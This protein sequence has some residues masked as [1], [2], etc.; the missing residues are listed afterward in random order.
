M[1]GAH[2]E[3]LQADRGLPSPLKPAS[4]ILA[5]PCRSASVSPKSPTA[6]QIKRFSS[7]FVQ[8]H[9]DLTPN[10]LQDDP[11]SLNGV[12]SISQ[13]NHPKDFRANARLSQMWKGPE[14]PNFP[15]AFTL[16]PCS[17]SRHAQDS[18]KPRPPH[19]YGSQSECTQLPR[20]SGVPRR[21]Q[22]CSLSRMRATSPAWGTAH[23]RLTQNI[24]A[25]YPEPR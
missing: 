9:G 6:L 10:P 14:T 21:H 18:E 12:L 4:C 25:F 22:A 17:T 8:G 1:W 2:G 7:H 19:P 3:A 20:V 24:G 16:D 11:E 23:C 13:S 5:L 15:S